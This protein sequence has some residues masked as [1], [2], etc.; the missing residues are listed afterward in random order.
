MKLKVYKKWESR[1]IKKF[2][3]LPLQI[4]QWLN[5]NPNESERYNK[6]LVSFLKNEFQSLVNKFK[7]TDQ[8]I[9][10]IL[11]KDIYTRLL[12]MAGFIYFDKKW[13]R[14]VFENIIKIEINYVSPV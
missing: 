11:K 7:L 3:F 8:R 10:K 2:L 5:N 1:I 13:L 4:S 9:E 14:D 6:W 12:I